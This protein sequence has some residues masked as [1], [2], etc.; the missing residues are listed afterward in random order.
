VDTGGWTLPG[1]AIDPNVHP[2]DAAV[3]ECLEETG[4]LVKPERL[5]GAFGGPEFLVRYRRYA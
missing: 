2:A 3:R 1:G 5:I 4:L